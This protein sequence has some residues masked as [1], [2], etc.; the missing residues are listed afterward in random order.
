M[1]VKDYIPGVNALD[2]SSCW[3][4][5]GNPLELSLL[6]EDWGVGEK[7]YVPRIWTKAVY[8]YHI[9]IY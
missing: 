7:A 9:L 6:I 8:Y 3:M 5:I 2:N 1:E 4:V